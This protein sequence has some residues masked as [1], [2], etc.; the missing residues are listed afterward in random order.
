MITVER[1]PKAQY[2]HVAQWLAEPDTRRWLSSYWRSTDVNEQLVALA[3]KSPKNHMYLVRCDDRAV[4]IVSLGAVDALDRNG[5]LWYALGEKSIARR[6]VMTEAVRQV[7]RIGFDGIGLRSIQA[8]IMASN[9]SSQRVLEKN[10]F[11]R[12][13][14]LRKGLKME[15]EFVDRIQYDLIPEDIGLSPIQSA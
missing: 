4:G 11:V 15:G 3:A 8:S 13:G 7:C 12:V 10:G 9:L 5:V 2:A 1:L 6:G 14:V